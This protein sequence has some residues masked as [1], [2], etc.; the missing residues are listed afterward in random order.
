MDNLSLVAFRVSQP[1]IERLR[2]PSTLDVCD[3][4]LLVLTM[5]GDL[6]TAGP[7]ELLANRCFSNGKRDGT[8]IGL[9]SI[10]KFLRS[11]YPP[12]CWHVHENTARGLDHKLSSRLGARLLMAV[13]GPYGGTHIARR[14]PARGGPLF[15]EYPF[16]GHSASWCAYLDERTGDS[17]LA[18]QLAKVMSDAE[19]LSPKRP[20]SVGRYATCFAFGED[21]LEFLGIILT[22]EDSESL[23]TWLKRRAGAKRAL[24][25]AGLD[26][27][28]EMS[29]RGRWPSTGLN[30]VEW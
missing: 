23:L 15:L 12:L 16:S 24:F 27:L 3:Q 8:A 10:F 30:H 6:E 29:R 4:T 26:T 25:D 22:K 9:P 28:V 14:L 18:T 21:D 11:L 20:I 19:W 13:P 5:V 1:P 2:L 17:S 7:E